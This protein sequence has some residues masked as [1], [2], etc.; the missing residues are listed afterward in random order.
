MERLETAWLEYAKLQYKRNPDEHWA[1]E[2]GMIVADKEIEIDEQS[3]LHIT[4]PIMGIRD[5]DVLSD[6]Q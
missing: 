2:I 5:A 1:K 4:D 3:V 6:R